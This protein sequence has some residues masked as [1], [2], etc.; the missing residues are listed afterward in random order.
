VWG[1]AT[2]IRGEIMYKAR[3]A[4]PLAYGLPGQLKGEELGN[5]LKWLIEEGKMLHPNINVKDR[6]C[7]DDKP[8]QHPIFAQLIKAQWW[9]PKGGGKR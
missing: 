8:W 3:M 6:T 4:V 2:Q 5:I 1:A 9:G 7:A